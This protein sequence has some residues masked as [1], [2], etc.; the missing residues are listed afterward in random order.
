MQGLSESPKTVAMQLWNAARQVV[1][2]IPISPNEVVMHRQVPK[3]RFV[4][5]RPLSSTRKPTC[6]SLCRKWFLTIERREQ[7]GDGGK[8]LSVN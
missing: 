8:E 2:G 5:E 6:V 1:L 7:A 3:K 4:A